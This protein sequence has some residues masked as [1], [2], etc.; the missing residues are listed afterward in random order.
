MKKNFKLF[1]IIMLMLF[2]PFLSAKAKEKVKVYMFEA[3]G[4]PYCEEQENYL[5]GLDSYDQKFELIKKE[6]YVDHVNWEAGKDFELGMKVATEFN[7]AGFE[8]ASYQG[9]PFVVISDVYA[10]AAYN[11]S[12]E[13][14]INTA[15]EK[16]DKDI[17]GCY[18]SGKT[19]CLDDLKKAYVTNNSKKEKS[20][21]KI[22]INYEIITI[23]VCSAV[24]GFL[25]FIKSSKDKKEIITLIENNNKV[26]SD[27]NKK[28]KSKK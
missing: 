3:G 10:A 23:I 8:D 15:Y 14:I 26:N 16:G 7:D 11:D 6:L 22:N 4:C 5:K 1:I 19:N 25:Y 13:D 21:K 28:S 18:E 12:L 24:L 9:T 27:K 2:I 17:V 20:N